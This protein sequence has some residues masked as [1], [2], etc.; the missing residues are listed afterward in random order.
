MC[1]FSQKPELGSGLSLPVGILS[2]GLDQTVFLN[3]GLD[4]GNWISQTMGVGANYDFQPL[5][6]PRK[7]LRLWVVQEADVVDVF[8]IN[9]ANVV[10]SLFIFFSKVFQEH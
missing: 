6:S 2:A 8:F 4:V 9:G 7:E 10:F 5:N 1:L 3:S